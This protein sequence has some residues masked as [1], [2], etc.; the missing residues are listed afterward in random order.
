MKKLLYSI[1][2]MCL[3]CLSCSKDDSSEEC[4]FIGKWCI[5]DFFVAG[6]C[7]PGTSIEFR[8]NGDLILIAS[9]LKWRS[10]DCRQIDIYDATGTTKGAEYTVHSVSGDIMVIDV[11]VGPTE[12]IRVN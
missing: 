7:F 4:D 8:S 10:D 5:E 2:I 3:M 12:Y 1:T 11:G 9:S 6:D